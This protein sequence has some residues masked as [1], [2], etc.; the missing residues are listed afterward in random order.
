MNSC[1]ELQTLLVFRG[2]QKQLSAQE[3]PMIP[4]C[5]DCIFCRSVQTENV[6]WMSA[7]TE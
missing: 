4:A 5:E 3:W 1:E 6:L 2:S 7:Q